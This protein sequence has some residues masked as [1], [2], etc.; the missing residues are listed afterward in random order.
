[1]ENYSYS[2]YPE[3]GDS[4]PRSREIDCENASWEEPTNY[5]VKFMCS[6]GGKISPRPH[7]NQLSYVG[8]DTKI[9]TVDRNVR[10]PT[11]MS[12]LSSIVDSP[13]ICFKYQLPGEE[14]DALISVTN[15]ED[16][17][18]MML[19]Y[20]RLYRA[21]AKPARLR[22][23]L[24]QITNAASYPTAQPT[25]QKSDRQWFVEA[26]NSAPPIQTI[27]V[28][29]PPASAAAVPAAANPDFLFGFDKATLAK[30][31]QQQEQAPPPE[32]AAPEPAPIRSEPDRQIGLDQVEI[33]RQIHE[34]Q[35]LQIQD[36]QARG[37]QGGDYYQKPQ[38]K[39]VPPPQQPP[40]PA[41]AMPVPMQMPTSYWPERQM[42]PPPPPTAVTI[43]PSAV[44][45][46]DQPVYLLP[47]QVYRPQVA[48][49]QG[50]YV[51][52][53]MPEMYREQQQQQQPPP[54]QPMYGMGPPPPQKLAAYGD[55]GVM[56]PQQ[57]ADSAAGGGYT[58]VA[59]DPSGRQ[60]FYTTSAPGGV[61]QTTY[62]GSNVDVR[63]LPAGAV[64]S[65]EGK[66]AKPPQ[67]S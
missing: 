26:L 43:S 48:A 11:M 50:Y 31:Q 54:Q 10:F 42:P 24:F 65:Q 40:P 30:M 9:L 67:T 57:V 27:E 29:S 47:T 62:Q 32:L 63:Q 52:R 1:M 41:A 8:G 46:S 28:P 22:L 15:D 49:G 53:M 5:R 66:V 17:D 25:E 14:L 21:S 33:Q 4:S 2:S 55:A 64:M 45:G 56:R 35:R 51:Q 20:D 13:D 6:Y 12:K 59:Y 37:F 60:V 16:L 44:T 23:F 58:G 7:D 38:E 34:L 39:P 61:V 3:S 19:E 36:Q 18:H